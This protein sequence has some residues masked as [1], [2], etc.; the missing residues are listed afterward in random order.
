M[1]RANKIITE[2]DEL[3]AMEKI[4]KISKVLERR[5]IGIHSRRKL[6]NSYEYECSFAPWS[7][8][9]GHEEREMRC[10]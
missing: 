1:D 8:T 6:K 7:R 4:F 10:P 5:I 3:A 2:D 9:S